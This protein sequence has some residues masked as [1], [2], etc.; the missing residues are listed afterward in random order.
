MRVTVATRIYAPE[1]AAAAFRLAAL[2]DELLRRGHTVDVLTTR[3]GN[4]RSEAQDG[5]RVRRARVKRSR[6]GFVRGYLSYLSFDVPLFFVLLTRR[7]PDVVV[8]EP[9]P[10]TGFVAAVVCRLRRVPMYWYA[11]DVW[12]DAAVVAGAPRFVTNV[13]RH[14]ERWVLRRA[15]GVLAVSEEVADRVAELSGRDAISVGNGVDTKVFSPPAEPSRAPT[16]PVFVYAGTS[17]EFQ[18]AGVF[19]EAL[20]MLRIEHPD[21]RL[22][23]LGGGSDSAA[24]AERAADLPPGAVTVLP[25]Q[26]PEVAAHYLGGATASLASIVPGVGYDFAVPTKIFASTAC[27]TPV[28]FA[29]PD[30]AAARVLRSAP[31]A[32]SVAYEATA[33]ASAMAEAIAVDA[34]PDRAVRRAAVAAWAERT[35][36][37][38]GVARRAADVVVG[39]LKYPAR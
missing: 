31:L 29:G 25:R 5:L 18:G 17:S 36:S 12:S 11:A 32:W 7:R 13:L 30:A 23:V 4:E 3:Y 35:G 26:N 39:E 8:V 2:V 20:A 38:G 9:P 28:V 33:V 34:A 21:A 6:D 22:V 24:L 37:L 16:P 10:T 19:V 14:V 1:P 15:V 27:G